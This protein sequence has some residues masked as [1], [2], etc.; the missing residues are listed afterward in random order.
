MDLKWKG[1]TQLV[2]EHQREKGKKL[3]IANQRLKWDRFNINT[4][5]REKK[6]QTKKL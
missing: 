1:V 5:S 2:C 4:K 6:V 3:K